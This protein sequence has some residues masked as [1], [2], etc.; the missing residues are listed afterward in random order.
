MTEVPRAYWEVVHP[1]F[2]TG[3]VDELILHVVHENGTA[4]IHIQPGQSFDD[5]MSPD[6]LLQQLD[7]L[8]VALSQIVMEPSRIFPH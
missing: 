3:R 5:T 6:D 7:H 4:R 1:N 2:E 8:Q